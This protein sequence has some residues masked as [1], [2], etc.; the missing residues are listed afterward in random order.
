MD[1]LRS[2]ARRIASYRARTP[3]SRQ[4]SSTHPSPSPSTSL[5]PRQSQGR[6][7]SRA[8]VNQSPSRGYQVYNDELPPS[9]QPQTPAHL[10]EARHQSRFH[11]SYTAPIT[12]AGARDAASFLHGGDGT[13]R[14]TSRRLL[15]PNFA[16]P[17]RSRGGRT[18]S[19]PG[20]L[21]D[22]F[23]GLYGGRENGDE[24]RNWVQGARY[25]N[26]EM[27]LWGLREARDDGRSLNVTPEPED[28]RAER[29]N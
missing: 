16:T 8:T 22:G 21:N 24:E 29:R 19:P 10:P 1:V 26:A 6:P 3:L 11:P 9:S 17:S 15:E 18:D 25:N 28:W 7:S 12:R 13:G 4:G 27:R 14:E 20:L 23:R 2:V 5:T